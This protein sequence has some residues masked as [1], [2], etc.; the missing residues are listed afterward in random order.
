MNRFIFTSYYANPTKALK[1]KYSIS[2]ITPKW[3]EV[4]GT[5][6]ELYPDKESVFDYKKGIITTAEFINIYRKKLHGL[7][8]DLIN[9]LYG[10]SLFC[11]EKPS[12]F[13][14]RHLL[15]EY[16]QLRGEICIEIPN[17]KLPSI[18][19]V[20]SRGFN[21]KE[22]LYSIMD[23]LSDMFDYKVISGGARGA[24]SLG[25]KYAVENKKETLIHLPDWEKHGKPAAFIRN[26]NIVDDSDIILAF[27]DGE[28]RGTKNTID[29]AYR[30][31]KQIIIYDYKEKRLYLHTM[32][33]YLYKK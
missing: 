22:I 2:N 21:D 3:F 1:E 23:E 8:K 11:Y 4:D 18:G 29:I 7:D 6:E 5:I 19:A 10:K 26:K 17:T 32:K 30:Q 20:G 33:K 25:E 9:S 16:L 15:R 14:H 24:D 13:C 27:W 12:D 31:H 28:S